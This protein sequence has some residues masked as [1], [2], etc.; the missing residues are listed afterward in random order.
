MS[1][2]IQNNYGGNKMSAQIN[3]PQGMVIMT[4]D[5]AT[6]NT[7]EEAPEEAPEEA[8]AQA[9]PKQQPSKPE[10]KTFGQVQNVWTSSDG[11]FVITSPTELTII[12]PSTNPGSKQINIE[13]TEGG[14]TQKTQ[15]N[16]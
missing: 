2:N 6:F 7:V 10:G 3:K 16:H 15:I 13:R 12:D 14:V 11:S 1:T 5:G 9:T 4:G 8:T